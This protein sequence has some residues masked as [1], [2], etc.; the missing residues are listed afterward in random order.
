MK[1]ESLPDNIKEMLNRYLA[2]TFTMSSLENTEKLYKDGTI[3]IIL[4]NDEYVIKWKHH[5][6]Y[7]TLGTIHDKL[8]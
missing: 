1:W 4:E 8:K 3:Q 5:N 7:R 6:E 2:Y